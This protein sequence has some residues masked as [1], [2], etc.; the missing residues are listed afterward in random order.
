MADVKEIS[1]K[2]FDPEKAKEI[3]ELKSKLTDLQ[4]ELELPQ[5]E[6]EDRLM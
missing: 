3:E 5:S 1:K 2:E 4:A 6:F